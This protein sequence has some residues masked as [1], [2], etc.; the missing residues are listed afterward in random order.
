MFMIGNVFSQPTRMHKMKV[1]ELITELEKLKQ[2]M[3]DVE[4]YSLDC[5][6]EKPID[7][8]KQG[9][10]GGDCIILE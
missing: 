5:D 7:K 4:V 6:Y 10:Y 9:Y 3:G 1:S 8:L 2:E